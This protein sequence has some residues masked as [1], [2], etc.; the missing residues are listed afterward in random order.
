MA[1]LWQLPLLP[2]LLLLQLL[3]LCPGAAGERS[4]A[5]AA[6][7]GVATKPEFLEAV[8]NITVAVGRDAVLPCVVKN[9]HDYKVHTHM[10]V[11]H[12]RQTVI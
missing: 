2:P 1:G 11:V 4:A 8:P 12:S 10:H 3:F 6:A 7:A 9:L 5:I